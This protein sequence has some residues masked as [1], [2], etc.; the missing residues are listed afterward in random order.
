[1]TFSVSF[2]GSSASLGML[3]HAGEATLDPSPFTHP[4]SPAQ[5]GKD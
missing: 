4:P 2:P 5:R 1:M 3:L